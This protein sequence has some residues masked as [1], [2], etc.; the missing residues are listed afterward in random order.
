MAR[1]ADPKP[2]CLERHHLVLH[3]SK[4]HRTHAILL[5]RLG[6]VPFFVTLV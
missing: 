4:P 2:S 3:R 1:D 6:T 5:L